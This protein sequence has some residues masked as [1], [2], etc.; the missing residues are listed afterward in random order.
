MHRNTSA[1]KD[2]YFTQESVMR[3]SV[4]AARNVSTL[5][6][7][8]S[9]IHIVDFSAANGRFVAVMKELVLSTA[10]AN[11]FDINPRD[12][13]VLCCDWLGDDCSIDMSSHEDALRVLAFNPPFG[14]AGRTAR[15]FVELG[16]QRV[17][18]DVMILILPIRNWQIS[19]YEVLHRAY[20]QP[21]AFYDAETSAPF[22][23]AAE[24]VVWQ[25]TSGV[26]QLRDEPLPINVKD[27]GVLSPTTS[28]LIRKVGEYAGRQG[29]WINRETDEVYYFSANDIQRVY[30]QCDLSEDA[31]RVGA[32]PW[33]RHNNHIV[34]S[35]DPPTTYRGS[36]PMASEVSRRRQGT[37]FLKCT[38]NEVLSSTDFFARMQQMSDVV[39]REN[40]ASGSPRS[41]STAIVARLWMSASG[42]T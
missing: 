41:I 13:S 34:C 4:T 23:V 16:L 2:A 32:A 28:L 9:R 37:G 36:N 35:L 22:N 21:N 26:V 11:Q 24:L 33:Y 40:L 10:T 8:S 5:L 29:Y 19:G 38:T 3:E 30:S 14:R 1:F 25:R 18:P 15:K 17:R 7:T 42:A 27:T 12:A 31:V 39:T 20:L 6:Q